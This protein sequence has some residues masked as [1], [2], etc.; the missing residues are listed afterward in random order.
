ML[1]SRNSGCKGTHFFL[2]TKGFSFFIFIFANDM[3]TELSILLPAFNTSCYQLVQHLLNQLE[4]QQV[5][6]NLQY[7]IVVAEDG[8]TDQAT[9]DENSKIEGFP[10]CRHIIR[11]TNAGRST[12]RNFLAQQAKYEWLLFIDS[13]MDIGKDFVSKYLLLD[14]VHV[15]YGG[16]VPQ[17]DEKQWQ[18]NLR[19]LYE[20]TN[21]SAHTCEERLKHPYKD[22]HTSNFL[23]KRSTLLLYPFNEH[24]QEYGYEDVLW[25][26]TLKE[27]GV[28]ITHIDN[29]V[30]FAIFEDNPSYL[31]KTETA[32]HT[33]FKFKEDLQDYSRLLATAQRLQKIKMS[34]I[35]KMVFSICK[36]SFQKNLTSTHPSLTIFKFYKLGYFLSIA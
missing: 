12:I 2:F 25:G 16:Y 8:S 11:T 19:Y 27:K 3:I 13:D 22:F 9:I 14:N 15:V 20:T 32:L 4:Q 29:P 35:V 1:L 30:I 18:G 31:Q 36:K 26:K 24:I 7:E 5:V 23:T 17:Q 28:P 6:E 10:N 33:L 34:E 21:L